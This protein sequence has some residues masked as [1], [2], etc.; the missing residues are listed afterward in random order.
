MHAIRGTIGYTPVLPKQAEKQASRERTFAASVEARP[1][2]PNF[3][4]IPLGV[5]Q[6]Y[7]NAIDAGLNDAKAD[8]F[9][10]DGLDSPLHRYV[11]ASLLDAGLVK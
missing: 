7:A 9:A 10:G 8:A 11:L 5:L 6:A 1:E 4:G 3:E 2:E